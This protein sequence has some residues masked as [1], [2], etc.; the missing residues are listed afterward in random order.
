MLQLYHSIFPQLIP[1][2]ESTLTFLHH[3]YSVIKSSLLISWSAAF[4]SLDFSF[5]KGCIID[6]LPIR[7]GYCMANPS[8]H[9]AIIT[10]FATKQFISILRIN[11]VRVQSLRRGANFYSKPWG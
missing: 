1:L 3:I 11:F 6:V 4:F 10:H 2:R 7:L 9:G 5:L 8:K